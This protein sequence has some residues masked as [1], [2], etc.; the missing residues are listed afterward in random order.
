M[1]R[2]DIDLHV[3]RLVL[4]GVAPGDRHRIG[5]AIGAELARLLT[6]YGL[7]SA[8]ERGAEIE[9]VDA[10]AF[11]LPSTPRPSAVGV[12]VARSVHRGLT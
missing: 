3:E 1:T 7:S 2:P 10:P 9:R 12:Q 11:T 4:H 6:A 8:L 5:D